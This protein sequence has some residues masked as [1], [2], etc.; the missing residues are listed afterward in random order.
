MNDTPEFAAR[1]GI[2]S[3][4]G[5]FACRR[6]EAGFLQHHL[7]DILREMRRSLLFCSIF[8][9]AFALTD[10]AVL[11][12]GPEALVL[13]LARLS[14]G[15][16]AV[17]GIWLSRR[18]PGSVATARLAATAVEAFGM[19]TF[20]LIVVLRPHEIMLHG[21]SMAIML[22]II[23]I[24]IPNRLPYAM[25]VALTATAAFLLLAFRVGRVVP[26]ELLT[27]AMLLLLANLFG[28][29]AAR[30]HERLR[31]EQFSVRQILT[32]LS[33]R[34]HLT[35]CYNRR[36]LDDTLLDAEIARAQR[37]A[38]SLTLIMCD[39]DRFKTINDSRGH[40]A[41]DAVLC[42]F[43]L[44]LRSSTREGVDTVV[45]Y[46]GEEFMLIL[47]DTALQG[48]IELA[49]RLRGGFEAAPT[50]E[51]GSGQIPATASFGVASVDFARPGQAATQRGLVA[52]ADEL[53]Y[54]A[55]HGGRNQVRARELA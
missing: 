9:I 18:K 45:R 52:A 50:V 44:L 8:Y 25:A 39:I 26:G 28:S 15:V 24:F 21:M 20:L 14:V 16:V 17:A 36:H 41:G 29:V 33:V 51:E 47:P 40:H 48:G 13:L 35:G 4:S 49:E 31:R 11:G 22:I 6:T 53:M 42:A 55:K 1:A 19:A 54:Q 3:L 32:N 30:R 5:E 43:A 27:M 7:A 2:E 34:D 37:S 12:Y 10:V 46:G 38:Q 23:Y